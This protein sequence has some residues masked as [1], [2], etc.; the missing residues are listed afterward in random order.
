MKINTDKCK[1][2]HTG[3]KNK[4]MRQQ[5]NE[6]SIHLTQ[7]KVTYMWEMGIKAKSQSVCCCDQKNK[8]FRLHGICGTM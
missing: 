5:A 3:H 2:M 1:V 8:Y 4:L 6:L 7:V